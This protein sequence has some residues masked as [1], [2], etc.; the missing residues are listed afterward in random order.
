MTQPTVETRSFRRAL[1]SFATGVT[2]ITARTGDGRPVGITANS[3]N[4]VSLDPP[5]VLW[6]LARTAGSMPAFEGATHWAVH[7]LAAD[8]E[9]LSNRF[10]Q[11]GTDKFAGLDTRDGAGGA[12]LLEGCATRLQCRTAFRYAGGDHVIFVGEVLDFESR[13]TAPLVFHGGR[14]ALALPKP[15][16]RNPEEMQ[17]SGWS[18]DNLGYLL[19]RAYFQ[20]YARIRP[21][22][23]RNNLD[24]AQYFALAVLILHDGRPLADINAVFAYSGTRAT[25][26]GMEALCQRDLLRASGSGESARYYLTEA[27]RQLTLRIVAAAEAAERDALSGLDIG[28]ASALRSLLHRF[29]TLTTLSDAQEADAP[30]RQTG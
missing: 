24:D 7:I 5:M 11:R 27:G 21:Q 3:F 10:A 20:L 14:Y 13:D 9:A 16:P 30:G 25:Q 28:D 19:G 26:E 18:A 12:P 23:E 17:R 1:G 2:V 29:V 4:S 22:A 15:E 8:Q 6:S